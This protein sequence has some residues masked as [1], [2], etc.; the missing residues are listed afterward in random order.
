MGG[1]PVRCFSPVGNRAWN[2]EDFKKEV[3]SLGEM[4]HV[5]SSP[6]HH[7]QRW[8]GARR[9]PTSRRTKPRRLLGWSAQRECAPPSSHGL[10]VRFTWTMRAPR[11]RQS[12]SCV[13]FFR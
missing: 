4:S 3:L 9:L 11:C 7:L 12:A 2:F 1:M 10:E 8:S 13:T 5:S 6:P